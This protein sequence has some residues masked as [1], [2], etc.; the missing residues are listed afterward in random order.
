MMIGVRERIYF[1]L[2]GGE[3]P[4]SLWKGSQWLDISDQYSSAF[5]RVIS[6]SD[7]H[8]DYISNQSFAD[9]RVES[10][11]NRPKDISFR[12]EINISMGK[13]S[14]FV[15]CGGVRYNKSR[16]G[17]S[18]FMSDEE[19]RPR[20]QAMKIWKS[21]DNGPVW[22]WSQLSQLIEGNIYGNIAHCYYC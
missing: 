22:S 17:I 19:V 6:E 21:V 5:F 14:E 11:L 1:Q 3:E 9:W 20:N 13:T 4:Q 16:V 7:K 10:A 12:K 8:L 18:F 2:P 15:V